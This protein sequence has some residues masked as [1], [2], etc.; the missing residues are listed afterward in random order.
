MSSGSRALS[1]TRTKESPKRPDASKDTKLHPVVACVGRLAR[2]SAR[3]K[4]TG[5]PGY[6]V[7][8]MYYIRSR[9]LRPRCLHA[10]ISDVEACRLKVR[11]MEYCNSSRSNKHKHK[12][13]STM[14]RKP[15]T[16]RVHRFPLVV[17]AG[18]EASSH[19]LSL[20]GLLHSMLIAL[21]DQHHWW[22]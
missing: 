10:C 3:P 19:L 5:V 12:P 21:S 22:Q 1:S 7:V 20:D 6:V 13:S 9:Y 2:S 14:T 17:F 4:T 8:V 18:K 16:I 11:N 15:S